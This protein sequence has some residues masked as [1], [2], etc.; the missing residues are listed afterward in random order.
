MC[1]TLEFF[2]VRGFPVGSLDQDARF[3]G[4][5]TLCGSFT[6]SILTANDRH[7]VTDVVI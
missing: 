5:V 2:L 6:S 4:S 1:P 3:L 7:T